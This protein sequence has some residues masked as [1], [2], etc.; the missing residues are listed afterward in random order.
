MQNPI[1]VQDRICCQM[2][3][4]AKPKILVFRPF[5]IVDPHQ[6]RKALEMD[7]LLKTS[8]GCP[9]FS[10]VIPGH[11]DHLMID[12]SV[13]TSLPMLPTFTCLPGQQGAQATS[14]SI[15]YCKVALAGGALSL[16]SPNCISP[17]SET[18]AIQDSTPFMTTLR[19]LERTSPRWHSPNKR[20][21]LCGACDKVARLPSTL[22]D[23]A[24]ASVGVP[25][26]REWLQKDLNCKEC[27]GIVPFKITFCPCREIEGFE[28]PRHTKGSYCF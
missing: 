19:L 16:A 24:S 11:G 13:Q 3:F 7:L 2:S 21:S 25:G 22:S 14:G 5:W 18:F 17:G 23:S 8:A 26:F 4:G 20:G 10:Q 6:K 12:M 27:G 1:S 28:Q 9:G 15:L